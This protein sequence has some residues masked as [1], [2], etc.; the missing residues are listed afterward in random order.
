MAVRW[1]SLFHKD[2]LFCIMIKLYIV[3][4]GENELTTE[5]V[6]YYV[7]VLLTV[8]IY[9]RK[10]IRLVDFLTLKKKNEELLLF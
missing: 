7:V 6:G 9:Q 4:K 5:Y 8:Q 3:L 1:T 10:K 2:N